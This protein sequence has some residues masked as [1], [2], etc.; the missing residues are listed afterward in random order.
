[1]AR[2]FANSKLVISTRLKSLRHCVSILVNSIVRQSK[3][4]AKT[5]AG[6]ELDEVVSAGL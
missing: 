2:A 1:M 5:N 4:V 6:I 3:Q